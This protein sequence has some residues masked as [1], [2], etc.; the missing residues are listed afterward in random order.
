MAKDDQYLPATIEIK[1][2]DPLFN[3]EINVDY[4]HSHIKVQKPEVCQE[5]CT[6]HQCTHICPSYV[7]QWT[8]DGLQ[9]FYQRCV[10]CGACALACPKGNITVEYPI[11]G[12]GVVWKY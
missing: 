12:A 4:E 3:L 1:D 7:Y 10:E 9:C 11:G 6:N 2:V 8:N 5:Q